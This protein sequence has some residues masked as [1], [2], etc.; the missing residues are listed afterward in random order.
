MIYHKIQRLKWYLSH[1]IIN[2]LHNVDI[3]RK[4]K[5]QQHLSHTQNVIYQPQSGIIIDFLNL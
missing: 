1:N 2:V 3:V 4:K 5:Q